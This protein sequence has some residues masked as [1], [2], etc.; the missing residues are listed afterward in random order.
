MI[1]KI[2]VRVF[3]PFMKNAPHGFEASSHIQIRLTI[4]RSSQF[5]GNSNKKFNMASLIFLAR[6]D[7]IRLSPKSRHIF[8]K[9]KL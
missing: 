3:W 5:L 1:A 6:M 7:R 9:V 2:T 4:Y 8:D